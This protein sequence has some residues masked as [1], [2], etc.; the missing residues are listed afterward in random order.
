MPPKKGKKRAAA[1]PES[2][3][4]YMEAALVQVL[5]RHPHFRVQL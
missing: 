4:D 3:D 5:D 1:Q 2:Y